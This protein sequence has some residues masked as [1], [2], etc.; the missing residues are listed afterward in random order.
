MELSAACM[1]CENRKKQSK[2]IEFFGEDMQI[3]KSEK[4]TRPTDIALLNK[5][6]EGKLH[7]VAQSQKPLNDFGIRVK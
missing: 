7:P 4:L 3:C 2:G 5:C 6:P 1:E